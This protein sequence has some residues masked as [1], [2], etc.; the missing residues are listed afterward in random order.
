MLDIFAKGIAK[1]FGTKSNRDIKEVMP[2]VVAINE[3]FQSY[4][5]LSNDELRNKTQ[6]FK[7]KIQTYISEINSKISELKSQA[8]N[9]A[10]EL[11]LK[12]NLFKQI[13]ELSKDRDKAIEEVLMEILPEAFAVVKETARRFK[14]IDVISATANALDRDLSVTKKHIRVEGNNVQYDTTWSVGGTDVK[15]EM[16]HYDV[17]LIG[18]IILHKGRIAEMATGEGKTLVATLPAYL[19]ALAGLGV[20]VVTVNDYLAKRDSE[21]MNPLFNFLGLQIECIDRYQPHTDERKKAY[22]ADVTYGTN[23][24]FGFDYLETIWLV[25]QMSKFKENII[26]QWWMRWT[27]Y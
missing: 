20:H 8:E 26:M 15:W 24:E 13:D 19:N 11:E 16:V 22:L 23:N 7:D 10:T 18:G 3:R 1:L 2:L 17:Q 9:E 21:W 25:L 12:D 5:S 14:E 6:E 4:Q 27:L